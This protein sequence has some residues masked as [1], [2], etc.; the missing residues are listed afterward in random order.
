MR[1]PGTGLV[2]HLV[3][4]YMLT[5]EPE[6]AIDQLERLLKMPYYL[7]PAWLA[8]DTTYDSLRSQPRFQRLV[9]AK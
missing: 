2:V 8:V 7:T 4:I 9:A 6:K 1:L 3:K 5:G